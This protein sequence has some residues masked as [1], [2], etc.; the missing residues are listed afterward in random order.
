[1]R[2]PNEPRCN[3]WTFGTGSVASIFGIAGTSIFGGGG[4]GGSGGLNCEP[5]GGMDCA[6]AVFTAIS[7]HST[8]ATGIDDLFI[9]PMS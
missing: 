7:A 2:S 6:N 8:A 3:P 4:G 9:E 1:M 5:P